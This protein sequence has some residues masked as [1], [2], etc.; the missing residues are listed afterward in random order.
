M[1]GP[2]DDLW[3]RKVL[4]WAMIFGAGLVSACCGVAAAIALRVT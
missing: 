2:E 4:V 3:G 1:T